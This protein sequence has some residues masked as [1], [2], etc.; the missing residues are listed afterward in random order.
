MQ[1]CIV[2]VQIKNGFKWQAAGY[3]TLHMV[4]AK[5]NVI[6]TIMRLFIWVCEQGPWFLAPIT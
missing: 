2:C 1:A 5:E 4:W 3:V 6:F